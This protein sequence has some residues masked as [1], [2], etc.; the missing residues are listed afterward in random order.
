MSYEE[1]FK[2]L[3]VLKQKQVKTQH[4]LSNI[5][6]YI[7]RG[8][9]PKGLQIKLLP[10][11]PGSDSNTFYRKWDQTLFHCSKR[12]LTLMKNHCEEHLIKLS[13]DLENLM[14]ICR[15][16]LQIREY[17]NI[18]K[19]LNDI[20]TIQSCTLSKRQRRKF[21]RDG[22]PNQQNTTLPSQIKRR[23]R[24]FKRK[25]LSTNNDSNTVVNLS[26]HH[27]TESETSLLA[28]GLNFCPVPGPI[29][30][31]KL[32]QELDYFARSLRIK[33]YFASKKEEDYEVNSSSDIEGDT[34]Y[35]F[36]KKSEWVPK[37]SKNT[38]LESFIDNVK[39][40]IISTV[41]SYTNNF[42]NLS[43]DER[44][45]LRN[46]RSNVEI[47]IKPADKGS[48]VVVMDKSAYIREAER[49]LNDDRFY[50]KLEEDPTEKFS[51]EI[52][53]ELTKMNT[54]GYID[55]KTL[56]YLTPDNPK[57]GRFYLLP[58]IH[59]PNNPG[60]PI[61][62]A[63]GHPTEKISEFVDYHLRPHVE[64]LPSFVKDT[65]DYLQKMAA[66][67][68]LP[69]GTT[70]VTMDV[71]SLYTN[72]PHADGIE[73][74]R[75][76]W[77]SRSVKDPPTECLVAMLTLVLKKNNFTFNG[78]H[79]L[80]IN[81]TAMGT[82]MAPSY[83]NIFMGKLEKELLQSSIERPLSWYRFIDDVDMKWI[84]TDEGLQN[85][86]TRANNIHPSIK[87]TYEISKS[88]I[89]FLDTS[90]SLSANGE[91]STDLY[92]K[93]TDTNQYL[94]PSSYHPPHVTKSIPYSQALRLR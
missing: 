16:K 79:F 86:I 39:T 63:N 7:V 77:E 41:E 66:L 4:H 94:L 32:S 85:F 81:G 9:I 90:S 78:D 55:D 33:E 10:Q 74:C 18:L 46:L 40:E 19:R 43:S 58:K 29:N 65:T 11:T 80:Q 48:A 54:L 27:L 67:N 88:S 68:P 53:K 59:K 62:S 22:I 93:P 5:N 13:S 87:F 23:N 57:A 6:N 64:S 2:H 3:R 89:S 20:A 73:A 82:K 71:T 36:V 37:P 25:S 51:D 12:L 91:L 24:H 31:T 35:R 44:T 76:V 26:S 52:T 30:S 47:V 84:H 8:V 45:A 28:K 42:D 72:I 21:N 60:R 14:I 75:E 38:T 83:A 49:Q 17:E 56:E 15:K 92:S 69:P 50:M 61:V 34:K 1:Y 70:L